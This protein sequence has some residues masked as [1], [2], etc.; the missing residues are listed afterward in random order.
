MYHAVKS[1]FEKVKEIFY[2]HKKWF[3]HVRTDYMKRMIAKKNLILENDVVITYNFYKRK[4]KIGDVQAFKGDCILHQIVAKTKGT[5]SDVLQRFFK[6]VNHNPLGKRVYLSV[7]SDN[8]MAK[9]FY[10]KNNMKLIGKTSWS[11]GTLPGDV[12]VYDPWT[13]ET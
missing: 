1:D 4:Q 13:Y 7:R 3:P 5:A 8:E 9:N 10:L 6:F 11:K 12:F 2:L